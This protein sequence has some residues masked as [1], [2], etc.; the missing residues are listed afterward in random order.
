MKGELAPA[1]HHSSYLLICVSRTETPVKVSHEFVLQVFFS[2]D[3]EDLAGNQL[4]DGDASGV[5]RMLVLPVP[6]SMP[7][8]RSSLCEAQA[9]LNDVLSQCCCTFERIALPECEFTEVIL[10]SLVS[11]ISVP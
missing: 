3:G 10:P 9:L 5:M 6:V 8:V 4:D 1:L 7:S 2:V 11:D